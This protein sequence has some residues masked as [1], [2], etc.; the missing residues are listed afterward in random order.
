MCTCIYADTKIYKEMHVPVCIYANTEILLP[1]GRCWLLIVTITAG[2]R[3]D[4]PLSDPS[5]LDTKWKCT[6]FSF[7]LFLI[8][9]FL[10]FP[11]IWKVPISS[12]PYVL[13]TTWK[14]TLEMFLNIISP[15]SR[16]SMIYIFIFTPPHYQLV[17][18][19]NPLAIESFQVRRR[20]CLTISR[21]QIVNCAL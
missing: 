17:S 21:V 11:D 13:D 20:T 8:F 7:F 5:K 6:L 2:R 16:L 10:I 1:T 3:H 15:L 9:N 18:F 12:D 19:P 4:T 14:C